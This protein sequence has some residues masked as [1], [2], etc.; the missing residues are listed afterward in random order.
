MP[1][2]RLICDLRG[3]VWTTGAWEMS[4]QRVRPAVD[5]KQTPEVW[6]LKQPRTVNEGH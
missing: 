6:V 3:F 5:L 4:S 2:C 1:H